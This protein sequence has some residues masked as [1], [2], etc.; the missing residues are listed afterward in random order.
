VRN[1]VLAIFL[2][3]LS[4][5]ST[6]PHIVKTT[7]I[8]VPAATE[9]FVIRD[10]W[11]TGFVIPSAT[12]QS[13]LPELVSRFGN[14]P[15]IEFGWGDRGYYQT[16]DKSLGLMLKAV[17]WPTDAIVYTRAI[18]EDPELYLADS[19]IEPLCLENRQFALLVSFIENSFYKDEEGNLVFSQDGLVE[20]SQFFK[21][22][23][24]YYLFNT[25]NT[26]TARG[27][28]SAGQNISPAFKIQAGSVM[29]SVAKN[30][31]EVA[32]SCAAPQIAGKRLY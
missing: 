10:G 22:V 7:E 30:T 16:D 25:C 26:W 20:N 1:L 3:L 29:R 2:L 23:G 13:R 32:L 4:A 6:K 18:P 31:P 5:C 19:E 9:I 21:G 17:L 24:D 27:L 14:T 28:K 8:I 11:H 15:Y 12:I